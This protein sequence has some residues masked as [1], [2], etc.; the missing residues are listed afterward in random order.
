MLN[1]HAARILSCLHSSQKR[2][3]KNTPPTVVQI[4]ECLLQ[5]QPAGG[6]A[7]KRA[8][9]Y[10]NTFPLHWCD[11]AILWLI[12]ISVILK[13]N[14]HEDW[15]VDSNY[16][17]SRCFVVLILQKQ[18]KNIKETCCWSFDQSIANDHN[19]T[20]YV[21]KAINP[22]LIFI[23]L[24]SKWWYFLALMSFYKSSNRFILF[25]QS[26]TIVDKGGNYLA[27]C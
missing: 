8:F 20:I 10:Y 21:S 4:L 25:L 1:Q 14:F 3:E 15:P 6:I 26:L 17:Q 16:E 7:P 23:K 24:K 27:D 22:Y 12:L 2:W 5:N 18:K 9:M 19:I 13:K 11:A